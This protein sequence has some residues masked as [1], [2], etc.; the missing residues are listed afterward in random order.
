MSQ[1]L[2]PI[3]GGVQEVV[4]STS[5]TRLNVL[6]QQYVTAKHL[7][8]RPT[9]WVPFGRP[10]YRRLP[11]TSET[12]QID[13]FNLVPAANTAVAAE[14]QK[15]GYTFVPWGEGLNSENSMFVSASESKQDLLIK[16]GTIVWEYGNTQVLP[17]IINLP[18][19]DVERSK[20]ELAYQLTYDDS[21]VVKLYEVKDFALTGLPLNITSSTDAI[22]GWRYY[23]VNAFLNTSTLMWANRDTY[24]PTFAQPAQ[25][26]LQWESELAMA[27][28]DITLRCPPGTAY[29]GTSTLSYYDGTAYAIVETVEIQADSTG[30]FFQF[31]VSP[32]LQTGWQVVFSADKGPLLTVDNLISGAGPFTNGT[33]VNVSVQGGSGS[34]ALATVTV[35]AGTVTNIEITSG[36]Y[37]YSVNDTPLSL[38]GYAGTYFD[39][40]L[41]ATDVAIQSITVSGVVTLLE[42]QASASTRATLVMYPSGT[43]PKTVINSEG[44]KVPATYCPLATVN[45]GVEYKVEGIE[46]NRYIIHRD[47]TPIADWLTKPFDETLIS[48]YEQ[49]SDYP[50]LWMAPTTS[51]KQEY[52]SLEQSQVT[53]EV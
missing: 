19:I 8:S 51:L 30:Q 34:G 26:Y 14:I 43:L 10:I 39:V 16:G 21:P 44:E 17:T 28:S 29:T 3:D 42:K 47:Y 20:Y 37:G 9:E 50:N 48:L 2:I 18:V 40:N 11:A 36:G 46:D 33:F 1:Q 49:V 7:E 25:S 35:I 13:F 31:T 32:R 12:Y 53:V 45:V 15:I 38:A 27:Y 41:I 24:L 5:Q 6:S 22:V 52:L 23:A 4:I